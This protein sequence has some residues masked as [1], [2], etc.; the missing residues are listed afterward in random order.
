MLPWVIMMIIHSAASISL[1]PFCFKRS[2][3]SGG[4]GTNVS[5][6]SLR[7]PMSSRANMSTIAAGTRRGGGAKSVLSI[8]THCLWL[9]VWLIMSVLF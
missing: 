6:P 4:G 7:P 9:I 5:A 3:C 8:L 2:S 1:L